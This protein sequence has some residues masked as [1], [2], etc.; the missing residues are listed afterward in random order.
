VIPFN[1]GSCTSTDAD[2]DG[3][4]TDDGAVF[5]KQQTLAVQGYPS[6]FSDGN[7]GVMR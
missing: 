4:L 1:L 5:T 7:S 3:Y 2:D 6:G